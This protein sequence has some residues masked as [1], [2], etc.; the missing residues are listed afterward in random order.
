MK[1]QLETVKC[2]RCFRKATMWCGHVIINRQK[3][4]AGWCATCFEVTGFH[5]HFMG[6]MGV[7]DELT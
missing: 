1:R 2:V 4:L 7:R 6:Q 5:G 3:I